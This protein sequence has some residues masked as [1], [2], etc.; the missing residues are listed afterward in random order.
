M[1]SK[2][3][4]NASIIL[5]VLLI[6]NALLCQFF[7]IPFRDSGVLLLSL[8]IVLLISNHKIADYGLFA[9]CC[10]GL[11]EQIYNGRSSSVPLDMDLAY[12]VQQLIREKLNFKTI[13]YLVNI[14]P[15]LVYLQFIGLLITRYWII[16]YRV[17]TVK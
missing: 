11:Y 3:R 2:Y 5:F 17:K 14:L 16:L 7:E 1:F 13:K 9:I 10:Y 15:I 12:P 8:I 4:K 6:I